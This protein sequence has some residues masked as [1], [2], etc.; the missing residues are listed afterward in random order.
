MKRTFKWIRSALL[1]AGVSWLPLQAL[2]GPIEDLK[3]GHWYEVPN[4]AMHGVIPNPPPPGVIGPASIIGGASGGAFDTK[5]DRLLVWGGGHTDYSGNE[6]YA[7]DLNTLKWT[8][9]TEPS[10]DVGG[11]ERS[12]YYPD[13]QPRGRHTYDYVEYVPP[14][15][16]FCSFGAVTMYPNGNIFVGN[17]DCLDM[18]T[19]KWQRKANALS[20]GVSALS[21]FDPVTGHVWVHG[22]GNE[23]YLVEYLPLKDQWMVHGFRGIESGFTSYS[24]TAAL[25]PKRRKF[26]AVG[27]GNVTVWN[28]KDRG[29]KKGK[30]IKTTG[31]V[32]IITSIAPGFVYDPI[33]DK[34]VAWS[35]G[36]D[37]YIFDLD[38]RLWKKRLASPGNKVVPTLAHVRGTFGRFAYSP[39]KNVYVVVNHINENVF[40][41][42]LADGKK[43]K[44]QAARP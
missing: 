37:V 9:L 12:G 39:R 27:N 28:L 20:Y 17:T 29:L 23:G 19:L 25:D 38:K 36:A 24:M 11:Y 15:D 13:G 4:S 35:G 31:D 34:F 14:I 1:M 43:G 22:A 7:F 2:G 10:K 3:P 16:S 32:G 41:Y 5:R 21:A 26:V 42:R 18:K 44:S 40:I 30:S 8:R 33:L 6:V